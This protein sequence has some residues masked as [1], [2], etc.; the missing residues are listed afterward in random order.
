MLRCLRMRNC[1]RCLRNIGFPLNATIKNIPNIKETEWQILCILSLLPS[2][3]AH[4]FARI[5]PAD[6]DFTERNRLGNQD[7]QD[8]RHK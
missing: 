1:D 4:M 3:Q 7:R 5:K 6:E 2:A 8:D